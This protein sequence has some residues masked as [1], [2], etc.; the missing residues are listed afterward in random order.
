MIVYYSYWVMMVVYVFEH[1]F[2]GVPYHWYI[3]SHETNSFM[4]FNV[5]VVRN[6]TCVQTHKQQLYVILVHITGEVIRAVVGSQTF[7]YAANKWPGLDVYIYMYLKVC[8]HG[9]TTANS[10]FTTGCINGI[11]TYLLLVHGS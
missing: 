6:W 9:R 10:I 8:L 4:A 3:E 1:K 2:H 7:S 5:S 11:D